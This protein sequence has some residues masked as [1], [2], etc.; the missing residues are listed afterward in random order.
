MGSEVSQWEKI[1]SKGNREEF[2]S[3]TVKDKGSLSSKAKITQG[4]CYLV[5][6]Q[7]EDSILSEGRL[8]ELFSKTE[9]NH[10]VTAKEFQGLGVKKGRA[11]V[12]E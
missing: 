7:L 10:H 4:I 12:F 8:S 9:E 5:Y 1:S 2:F 6:I 11:Q 3:W